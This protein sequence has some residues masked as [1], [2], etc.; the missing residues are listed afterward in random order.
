MP[1]AAP[2]NP[3]KRKRKN[4][5]QLSPQPMRQDAKNS[6]LQNEAAILLPE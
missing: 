3:P 2:Q 4:N 6:R 5:P 1:R